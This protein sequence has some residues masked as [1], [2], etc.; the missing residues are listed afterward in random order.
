MSKIIDLTKAETGGNKKHPCFDSNAHMYARMHLPVAPRCNISCNYCNRKYDCVN[1]SRPGVCSSVLA[2][3]EA[4]E[5]FLSVRA[6]VDN[7]KVVGV[8][9][10]GDALC[11][12][13][14]T[15]EALALIRAEDPEV[16][17]CL[18]TNGLLLPKY[19]FELIALGIEYVTVTINAVDPEIGKL[20]CGT[21]RHEGKT[22]EGREGAQVLLNSQLEGLRF[23]SKNGVVCKVNIVMIKGVNDFHIEEIVKTVRD[24]GAHISNIMPLIPTEGTPFADIPPHTREEV[25]TMRMHCGQYLKQMHHCRQCRADA[26]GTLDKDRSV[27][28]RN[29]G[30]LAEPKTE[31]DKKEMVL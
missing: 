5:L 22:L 12:F 9:G 29:L 2:P 10:P 11:D 28:F 14:N 3:A 25:H 20:I 7:L 18:S 16:S 24:R 1:E 6:K 21:V 26:I 30:C 23:L 19:A 27:E 13:E 17:F 15:K 31:G 4:L 8:A